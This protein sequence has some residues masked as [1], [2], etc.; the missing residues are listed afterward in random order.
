MVIDAHLEDQAKVSRGTS[1]GITRARHH[2]HSPG[3]VIDRRAWLRDIPRHISFG[4]PLRTAIRSRRGED[5][6]AGW[7]LGDGEGVGVVDGNVKSRVGIVA[8]AAGGRV[9]VQSVN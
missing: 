6:C 2:G 8:R 7:G 5:G 3:T 1:S 9:G 4:Q